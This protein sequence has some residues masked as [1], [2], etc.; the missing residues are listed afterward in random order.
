MQYPNPRPNGFTTIELLTGVL[1]ATILVTSA[2]P[3]FVQVATN[4]RMTAHANQLITALALAKSTAVSQ[5]KRVT[6]CAS[7]DQSTCAA[8]SSDWRYGWVLFID[9][10]GTVGVRDGG[11]L[12]L[13]AGTGTK[14]NLG[15]QSSGTYVSY[16]SPGFLDASVSAPFTFT[17]CDNAR[18]GEDGRVV[19]LSQVGRATTQEASGVC[20]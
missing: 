19:S 5:G 17:L 12:I 15:L 13:R 14:G 6:L 9:E 7:T 18:S 8:S 1:I 4:N 2:A 10:T 3:G 20:S 11:D 16:R